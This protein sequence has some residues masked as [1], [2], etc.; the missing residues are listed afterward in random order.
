MKLFKEIVN[1]KFFD[2]NILLSDYFLPPIREV[3][4][5]FIRDVFNGKKMV[6]LYYNIVNLKYSYYQM[7][8]L[9]GSTFF[10]NSVNWIQI[11]SIRE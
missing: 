5:N 2:F 6:Y 8:K 3:T 11:L 9:K 7:I 4:L 10:L 1:S